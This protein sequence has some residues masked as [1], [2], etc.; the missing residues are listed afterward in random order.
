MKNLKIK[1]I[2]KPGDDVLVIT[3]N[4]SEDLPNCDVCKNI[5]AIVNPQTLKAHRCPICAEDETRIKKVYEIRC[6][7]VQEVSCVV[8]DTDYNDPTVSYIVYVHSLDE[9]Q[10]GEEAVIDGYN[11][12][13]DMTLFG[14]D[15]IDEAN[16]SLA[17]LMAEETVRIERL[18]KKQG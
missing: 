9:M 13:A 1:V 2:A 5:R 14:H 4:L 18:T 8:D 15:E 12:D 11:E 16:R 7:Y 10:E 3:E 6:G 17:I